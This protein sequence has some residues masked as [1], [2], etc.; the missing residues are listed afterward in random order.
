MENSM[1][2]EKKV[3]YFDQ[4]SMIMYGL[5]DSRDRNPE[6]VRLVESIVLKQLQAIVEEAL[7]YSDGVT[8][9]G[10]N[11]VFLL[12]HNKTKMQRFV[13]YIFN[14][15]SAKKLRAQSNLDSDVIESNCDVPPKNNL[16]DFIERIDETGEFTDLSAVDDVKKDREIRAAFISK[17]LD[18]KAYLDFQKARC[19]SFKEVGSGFKNL[20]LWVHPK[21]TIKFTLDALDVLSY[22]AY[23][24]VAEIVDYALLIRGD[25]RT[26]N[27][28]LKI[29]PGSYYTS[30]MFNGSHRDD[31][32]ADSS[33]IYSNQPPITV[34]EILEVMRRVHN[35]QTGKLNFGG[36]V[37]ETH[38]LFAL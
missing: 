17:E 25:I 15:I 19:A 10:E 14:K 21:E 36:K 1:D 16:L 18:D 38:F 30:T 23:Q 32:N 35:S 26:G 12:R 13:R 5:G 4:I 33:H 27:D 9:N 28:P 11:L 3:S 6:T 7:K 2:Q 31:K 8:L 20:K 37:P 29:T 22:F 24:T 34:S